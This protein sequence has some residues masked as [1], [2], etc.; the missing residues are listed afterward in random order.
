MPEN[1]WFS[2]SSELIEYN[3]F[4]YI[5]KSLFD[6]NLAYYAFMQMLNTRKKYYNDGVINI[7]KNFV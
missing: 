2:F 4:I 3:K 7:F 1:N 6:N 5:Y